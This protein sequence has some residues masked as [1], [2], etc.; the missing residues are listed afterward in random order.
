MFNFLES[1]PYIETRSRFRIL[2]LFYHAGWPTFVS[3]EEP[4]GDR[5]KGASDDNSDAI[6]FRRNLNTV[7]GIIDNKNKIMRQG[8]H[9]FE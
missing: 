6:D 5:R 8:Q 7:T 9:E 2:L 3:G 4:T 1:Y